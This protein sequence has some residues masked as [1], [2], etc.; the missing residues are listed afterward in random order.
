MI[1]DA[2]HRNENG[3]DFFYFTSATSATTTFLAAIGFSSADSDFRAL[4]FAPLIQATVL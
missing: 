2:E 1:N 4:F 3:R